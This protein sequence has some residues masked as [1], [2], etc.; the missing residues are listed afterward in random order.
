MGREVKRVPVGFDWPIGEK[1]WGFM[2]DDKI[3][4]KTCDENNE[5]KYKDYCPSCYGDGFLRP[6]FEVPEGEAYQ[7]WET[8][9][10]GSPISPAFEDPK[11]LAKWLADTG[12]SAMG[13]RTATYDQW[14]SMIMGPGW[15]MTGV[16]AD[17]KMMNGV[18]SV[19]YFEDKE[20]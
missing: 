19:K 7:M 1:W 9:S 8:T 12:A 14:L 18:E 13:F 17:G 16:V 3:D 5:V 20:K 15:V 6:Y 2:L 11:E 10:E 4:C